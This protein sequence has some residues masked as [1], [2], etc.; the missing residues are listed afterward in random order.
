MKTKPT[1][2]NWMKRGAI[3]VAYDNSAKGVN[4]LALLKL[5]YSKYS[6]SEDESSFD[7][8]YEDA[9]QHFTVVTLLGKGTDRSVAKRVISML[10]NS[11]PHIKAWFK[12][13]EMTIA[14]SE[15]GGDR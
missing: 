2:E 4:L 11:H 7:I 6:V 10:S 9:A 8:A 13:E 12:G 14:V 15:M 3:V 5:W 1:F